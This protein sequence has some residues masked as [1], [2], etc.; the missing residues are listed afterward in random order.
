MSGR[1]SVSIR[2]AESDVSFHRCTAPTSRFTGCMV[3]TYRFTRCRILT[4]RFAGCGV[5]T[6]RFTGCRLLQQRFVAALAVAVHAGL[7][8]R[9]HPGA[10]HVHPARLD[11]VLVSDPFFDFM[12]DQLGTVIPSFGLCWSSAVARSRPMSGS[13]AAAPGVGTQFL[14]NGTFVHEYSMGTCAAATCV[15]VIPLLD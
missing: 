15:V 12:P 3:L 14:I 1:F 10:A 9:H 5:L 8:P 4:R 11:K 2:V 7:V 13:A 6:C